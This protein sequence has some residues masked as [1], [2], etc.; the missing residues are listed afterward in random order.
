MKN[1]FKHN[2]DGTTHIFV[3]TKNKN[4]PGKHTIIIDTEDWGKVKEHKWRISGS[5]SS[6]PYAMT[7]IPHPDGEWYY[8]TEKGKERRKRRRTALLFHHAIMGKPQKGKVIDHKNH[9][10]I[11]TGLDN[12]KDNL[13]EVTPSQNSQNQRSRKNSS[14]QYK[15]VHWYTQTNRWRAKLKHRSKSIH[16]GYFA[17]EHQAALAYNKKALELWGENALL[18]EVKTQEETGE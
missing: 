10:G 14:S 3:E 6:Y 12:R 5:R 7:S 9:D 16:V 11:R 4:F 1:Q 17:C 18:N 13:R 2:E 15:G 8:F